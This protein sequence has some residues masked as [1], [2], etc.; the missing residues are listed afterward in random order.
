MS[1]PS[2]CHY[3]SHMLRRPNEATYMTIA[4]YQLT[5]SYMKCGHSSTLLHTGQALTQDTS[6]GTRCSCSL[7]ANHDVLLF[8]R[9]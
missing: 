6:T 7:V 4:D 8:Q 5:V 2:Q 1:K 9:C 3:L